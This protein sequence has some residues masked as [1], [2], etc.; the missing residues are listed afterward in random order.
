MV[1]DQH[2]QFFPFAKKLRDI[3]LPNQKK[4]GSL[5]PQSWFEGMNINFFL[6]FLI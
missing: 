2:Q 6:N 5:M 1:I 3:S 4:N